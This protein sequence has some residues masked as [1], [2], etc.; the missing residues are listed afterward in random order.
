M[1]YLS[2]L[3][4]LPAER[5]HPHPEALS[6]SQVRVST[7]LRNTEGETTPGIQ[8]TFQVRCWRAGLRLQTAVVFVGNLDQLLFH[9]ALGMLSAFGLC[10][11]Q[12]FFKKELT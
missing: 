7:T 10:Y 9:P 12:H 11:Q 8:E 3:V 4:P 2:F 1:C 6:P 5:P